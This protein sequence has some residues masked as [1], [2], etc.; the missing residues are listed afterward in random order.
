MNTTAV[1]TPC[2]TVEALLRPGYV[3]D[4]AINFIEFCVELDCQDDRASHPTNVHLQAQIDGL[5][6]D[7]VPVFDSRKAIAADYIAFKQMGRTGSGAAG[8]KA[9]DDLPY[10]RKLFENLE[11][12]ARK[13]GIAVLTQQSIEVNPDLNGFGPWQNAWLLYR[14]R[15]SNAGAYAIAIRGT[16]FS[17]APSA[18]ED[19]LFRPAM[20]R[21]FRSHA[22]SFSDSDIATLHS[23][24][25]N[26]TF[27][28]LLDR[29]YGILA[30]LRAL[31]VPNQATLYVVGHSQ[32]AAMATLVHA[33]FHLAMRDAQATGKDPLGLK[34]K[35]FPIKSYAFAQPKPGNYAFCMSFARI[36]QSLGNAIVI[37]NDLDP[38]PKVPFTLES[39]EDLAMDF[40]GR[41]L[42]SRF[43]HRVS[44]FG[45]WFR[46]AI[47]AIARMIVRNRV[48]GYGNVYQIESLRPLRKA[49]FGLSWEFAP[50][51]RVI[52]VFGVPRQSQRDDIFFQ[53]HATTYRNLIRAQLGNFR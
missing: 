13:K 3:H 10:W 4:E 18:L 37:N 8:N 9:D 48:Q 43:L 51:G 5:R 44:D 11:A 33:F 50:A 40:H 42:L 15:G 52:V 38:V 28:T 24:F 7:P 30:V 29:R 21:L 12:Q 47:P 36:T 2:D 6:W 35:A 39:T 31:A 49:K 25:A 45:A 19:A 23:G 26:A 1:P 41:Y 32:G 16:V 46:G 14:G 17:N 22:V 20:A 34:E 27:T 53:H